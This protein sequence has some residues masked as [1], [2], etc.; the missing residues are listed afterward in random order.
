MF[1]PRP[2]APLYEKQGR[3][4]FVSSKSAHTPHD[5]IFP[6][7]A[8]PSLGA[9]LRGGAEAA[10]AVVYEGGPAQKAGL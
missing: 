3:A 6:R 2:C 10:L 1:R 8:K 5:L 9:R 7:G 4:I